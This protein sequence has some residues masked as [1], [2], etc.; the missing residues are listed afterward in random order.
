MT[1][2]TKPISDGARL[3]AWFILIV[4][5]LG[6]V[7]K[8]ALGEPDAYSLVAAILIGAGG[9]VVF[10]P[11]ARGSLPESWSND[12]AALGGILYLTNE[13]EA[14]ASGPWW[15]CAAALLYC[16]GLAV[17][18]PV[19]TLLP[20]VG[21]LAIGGLLVWTG[22]ALWDQGAT[23]GRSFERLMIVLSLPVTILG[24]IMAIRSRLLPTPRASG[25]APASPPTTMGARENV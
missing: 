16:L 24:G 19:R 5:W 7:G 18:I 8:L 20:Q 17:L 21:A 15:W 22:F 14:A 11:L 23:D 3:G 2:V 1:S 4:L 25:V 10:L 12:F 13:L 9:T 6:A